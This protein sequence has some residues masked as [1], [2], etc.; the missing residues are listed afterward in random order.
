[1]LRLH[2]GLSGIQLFVFGGALIF[3]GVWMPYWLLRR[4]AN[5]RKTAIRKTLPDALDLLVTGVEAGLGVDAAFA[6]VASRVGGPVAETFVEYLRQV[7]LG[8]TRRE[9]LDNVAQRSGAE[10]LIRLANTVAQATDVGTSMG[11]VLRLQAHDLRI[12]RRARAQDAARKAPILMT[13]PL[14]LCFMPAMVAVVIVPA[15]LNTLKFVR[16]IGG[17]G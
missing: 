17:G 13:I 9:A 16:D 7:G 15:I 6:L 3:F 10:D 11:D 5:A 1:M 8:R 12:E 14:A 4:R 2:S